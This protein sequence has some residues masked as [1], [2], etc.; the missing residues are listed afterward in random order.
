MSPGRN[1]A[2]GRYPRS[3][4][5]DEW[6]GIP[7]SSDRA[8]WPDSAIFEEGAHPNAVFTHVMSWKRG[9]EPIELEVYGRAKRATIDREITDHASGFIKRKAKAKRPLF[10]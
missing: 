6:Y 1:P 5:F 9:Q 7:R 3:Q 2:E 4:G 10:A 8:Y